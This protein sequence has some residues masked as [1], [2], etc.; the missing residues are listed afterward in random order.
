MIGFISFVIFEAYFGGGAWDF[1]WDAEGVTGD[2][3]KS[4]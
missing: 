3:E 2:G 4:G 1:T